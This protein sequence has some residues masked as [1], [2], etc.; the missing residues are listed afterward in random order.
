MKVMAGRPADISDLRHLVQILG[1]STPEEV[2]ETIATIYP[3]EPVSARSRAAVAI[4]IRQ[5]DRGD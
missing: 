1:Y 5:L 2:W 3:D 4:V